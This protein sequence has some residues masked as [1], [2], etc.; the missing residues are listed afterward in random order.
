MPRTCLAVI[1]LLGLL[2]AAHAAERPALQDLGRSV[3]MRILVD[4]VM[5]PTRG[6]TT[7]EWMVKEAAD[8]GFNVFS[9]RRGY[10]DLGEVRKVTDWCRKYGIYHQ[11]WMRGVQDVPKDMSQSD[12]R[13]LVWANGSEQPLWSPNSDE[14]WQWMASYIVPYA[15]MGA[16]DHTLMGVFLD[17]ENYW[18]GGMGNLYELS[19]DDVIMKL[20]AASKGLA[21]PQLALKDRKAWLEEQKLTDAFR[22]FQIAH[23]RQKCRELRQAVDKVNPL[24]QFNIYP[25]PGTM[26]MIEA[27]YPEW[28]T[29]K[30]PLLLA[31]PWTYGRSGR[32]ATHEAALKSNQ[33][34]IERGKATAAAKN[35]NFIYL[36]GIDP[37]VNGADPEFCGKNA[38]LLTGLTDGYWIFYEGPKYETTHPDYFKWFAWAN[39]QI[40]AK[41]YAAAWQPRET[42]D[43]SGFPKIKVGGRPLPRTEKRDYPLVKL[44]GA[45][46]LLVAGHKDVPVQ[47]NLQ[48]FRIG[49]NED[50]AS[51]SFK[52]TDWQDLARGEVPV[53]TSGMI[54]YTPAQD[55][56]VVL[57]IEA[58]G[59]A[60]AVKDS[61]AAL[62]IYAD[63][64][65]RF[66]YG[67]EKLY[68]SVPAGVPKFA[69]TIRGGSGIET[70]KLTV[71]DPTG[72]GVGA[73]E[74]TPQ[75]NTVSLPVTVGDHGGK[76]WSLS[77]GKATE[78]VLED[79][80]LTL[81]K[82]LPQVL[83][84]FADEVFE[85]ESGR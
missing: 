80:S 40:E 74:A 71:A 56:I 10:E 43:P 29:A 55:G 58:G 2:A 19:Y 44:R 13:R 54:T 32:Y 66:I 42:E 60:Y 47:I 62:A 53:E 57:L 83:S 16:D 3:K 20:F 76:V 59:N 81:D 78:G 51:W 11:P 49:R 21:L 15:E 36:G 31:D 25:A 6:W 52:S 48:T 8:A 61:N 33:A 17:Y 23:W 70:V 72:A 22:D 4:K 27:C 30:A 37:V 73:V 46:A 18:P 75:A 77:I 26:F 68:F 1:T 45:N 82:A 64:P 65:A 24:F 63:P 7:E 9:P 39:K 5:Q 50:P 41:D 38:L 14:L 34:I 69:L 84:Y 85:L 67:A 79:N 12:G 35:I 28:A